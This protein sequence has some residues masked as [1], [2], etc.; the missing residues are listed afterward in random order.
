MNTNEKPKKARET[1]PTKINVSENGTTIS[2]CVIINRKD[3]VLYAL[4]DTS[5]FLESKRVNNLKIV[6]VVKA[7]LKPELNAA[8]VR[9][10]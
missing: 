6:E 9:A 2:A 7:S 10:R 4:G 3:L 8:T 1:K 5:N